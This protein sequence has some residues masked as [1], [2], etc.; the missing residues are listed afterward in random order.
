MNP[1]SRDIATILEA[2][3]TLGL[4]FADN[5]FVGR[6]PATPINVVTIFDTP[7]AGPL[8][9]LEGKGGSNYFYPSIQIR[10]RSDNYPD[11]WR[12]IN[13]IKDV[14]HGVNGKTVNGT[15]YHLI[16]CATSSFLL[17]W[18]EMGHPRFVC[19]FDCQ[20]T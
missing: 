19:N 11:G 18:D 6:E 7:G 1:V 4:V 9:T 13:N 8:L 5:L 17:D 2:E 16:R 12:W 10:V 20:R 14:L 3:P 15:I